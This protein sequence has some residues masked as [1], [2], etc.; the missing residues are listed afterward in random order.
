MRSPIRRRILPIAVLGLST[1]VAACGSAHSVSIPGVSAGAVTLGSHQPLTG[2]AAPG[3]RE[4][5]AASQA[6]FDYVNAH[7]GVYG[8]SIHLMTL[9]DA[10]NPTNTTRVVNQLVTYDNVFA[11][12]EG[13]GTSTHR[14]VVQFLNNNAVPDLF[15]ASGCPCWNNPAID[16]YT[17]G[18]SPT[19]LIEG[20]L[21]GWY[22]A[23]HFP[24]QPVGVLYQDDPA[25]RAGLVGVKQSLPRS[26]VVAQETYQPGATTLRSQVEALRA[27]RATVLID[28]TLPAYT[29]IE[30]LTALRLGFHPHLLVSSGGSDPVT[31]SRLIKTFSDGEVL[32]P[33]LIDGAVT[34]SYLPSP[35]DG[36]NPW[37]RLFRSINATYDP[38][39]PFDS[40]VEYGMATAYTFV[41]ALRAA[42]PNLTRHD[43]I[44][45]IDRRGASW[46]GPGLLPFQYSRRD[47]AGF[48]GAQLGRIENGRL[49]LFGQPLMTTERPGAR[50]TVYGRGEA[51]PPTNGIP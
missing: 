31:V 20:K 25:G 47:H 10:Y 3:Y 1:A 19:E 45:A 23:H 44:G 13:V 43:L 38:H 51:V 2:P 33:D 50:I 5:S 28:F 26:A 37:V 14:Q 42:G 11:M 36:T 41:Q 30:Q 6:F 27:S 22:V 34:D 24:G 35:S 12:F 46:L 4:I 16:P 7:G 8:R 48:R 49:V 18:W 39:T 32:G 17:Y 15:V 29:A 21:L 40:N 9:N